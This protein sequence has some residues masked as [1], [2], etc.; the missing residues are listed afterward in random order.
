ML[1]LS[2]IGLELFVRKRLSQYNVQYSK[3]DGLNPFMQRVLTLL[4]T[5]FFVLLFFACRPVEKQ[6]WTALVP[7]K[8]SFLI[9]PNNGITISNL[10]ETGYASLLEDITPNSIQQISSFDPALLA[11]ISL[12]GLI[13]FPSSA[14][15]SELIWITESSKSI[16]SWVTDFYQAFAQNYYT[17]NGNTIHKITTENNSVL[18]AAQI[19]EW[20]IFSTS[21]IAIEFSL[22][23]YTGSTNSMQL[24]VG[25]TP[26]QLVMNTPELDG[27][28]EQF[29]NV[30]YRPSIVD[31]FSG[32]KP[33]S[34]NFT[35][36]GDSTNTTFTLQGKVTL[37]DTARSVLV[38]AVS[39]KN[40]PIVLDRYISSNAAAF[41]LFRLPPKLTPVTQAGKISKLDSLLL[42]SDSDYMD[43][44]RTLDDELAFEAFPKSGLLSSGEYLFMRKLNNV[45]GL[46]NK[47][48]RL[49]SN[50]F[51]TRTGNSYYASSAVLSNLLGSELSP[52]T[53]F[54]ISFS[55]S[56]VVI[57]NRKGLSESVEADRARR[58]VIYYNNDYTDA[59]RDLPD[60]ISGFVWSNSEDF[61][62]FI[63]P[64]L[65]PKNSVTSLLNQFDISYITMQRLN[66]SSIDFT[67]KTANK[68][69]STQPYQ[70]LWVSP[71][72]NSNL[73]GTPILGDIVGSSSNEI[74]YS[75]TNGD[76]TAVA[77][78]G[79]IVMT[80]STGGSMP[81][82]SP[83]LY[84]WYANNQPVIMI[85]AGTKIFAWNQ[86]GDLLPQF[87]IELNQPITAPIVV[88]DVRRNGI[89]EIIAATEDRLVH[90]IDRR[91]QNVSGWPQTVNAVVTSKPLFAQV[92][93]TW[94]IWVFS[95]NILHGWLRSGA[96]R[97]GYPQFINAGF[98]GSP[99]VFKNSIYGAASDGNLY[100]IG[101]NPSIIDSLGTFI[102]MDSVSIKSLYVTNNELLSVDV[103]ERIL[104]KNE[105]GFFR[106]DLL[107][108]QSRNG[109]I[110]GINLRGE[111]RLTENLGQPASTTLHPRFVDID[112]DRNQNLIALAEFGRLFSW[113]VLTGERFYGL[114]TSG[115]KYPIITDLDGDGEKELIAQTR[116]GLRC[117]TILR[118]EE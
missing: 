63:T 88:T 34:L 92:D 91:G 113:D 106:E 84:D 76:I 104:L 117:W 20:L 57:S 33:S 72:F 7:S 107:V 79:T 118:D 16:N 70:E 71:L 64:F 97:P 37:S 109:S 51:I 83:V 31:A 114:P 96:T 100:S 86:N 77:A 36:E 55:R 29:A 50:G 112:S 21:S 103:E 75:T 35:E 85:G 46:R 48:N 49:A 6:P 56:V 102:R 9:I 52:Y 2:L 81:I 98:N 42:N 25:D 59:R 19:H 115:M 111:L 47:L 73:T 45:R 38:D 78:D 3:K 89:P 23:S 68:E 58:R 43:I 87:P 66:Q 17:L 90:V 62:E 80:A 14:T 82:G 8:S 10:P 54:Y 93:D 116:E 13:L 32:S 24:P 105:E 28:V 1:L 5:T 95:Q 15:E 22:R 101:K 4:I 108:T 11:N 74:I 40:T 61:K 18:Y 99:L 67:F 65:L 69:G 12:K 30:T 53:D 110:F 41:A 26:G 60:E 44:A 94:S 27:W 39:S